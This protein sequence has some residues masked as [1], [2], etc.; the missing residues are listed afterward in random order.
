MMDMRHIKTAAPLASP[1]VEQDGVTACRYARVP[2]RT[3]TPVAEP[4][5]RA[6]RLPAS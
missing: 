6:N 4:G 1:L 5:V 3:S 2:P